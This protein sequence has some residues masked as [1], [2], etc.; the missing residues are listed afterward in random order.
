[1]RDGHLAPYQELAWLTEPLDTERAWLA[2]HDTPLPRADHRAARRRRERRISFPALGDHARCA[3]AAARRRRRRGAAGRTSSTRAPALA[4]AG[5]RFLALGRPDAAGRRPARRGATAGRPTST[6]GS[7]CSR[8]TRCAA[9]TPRTR[10]R[11]PTRYAAIGA[12]L[13]ELGFQL[14]RQRDPPRHVGGRPAAHRL[15]GQGARAGRGAGG[16]DGGARRRAAR[17]RPVRRRAGRGA[18]RRR[19]RPAC[20]T[21][22][23]ARPATRCWRSRDDS[24][25]APL[26]PLLVSGR[27]LRC[28][29]G[30][31]DVAARGARQRQAAEHFALP[32]WEAEP[33]RPARLAAVSGRGVGAARVGRARHAR[34]S[35]AASTERWSAPAR[36]SA[37]AG[38]ARRS[39]ASSTSRSPRPAS[40]CSRCAA[41]RCGSTPP[42]REK[43]ASNWD[44]VCV[45]PEPRA[46]ERRLRALRAQAPAPVRARRGRRD[47]GRAVARAPGAGPVRAA[48]GEPASTSSTARCAP[49]PAPSRRRASAGRSA[50]PTAAPTSARWS[51]ADAGATVPLSADEVRGSDPPGVS[52]RIPVGRG[53]GCRGARDRRVPGDRDGAA[54]RAAGG[55][56]AGAGLGG[57]PA[58]AGAEAAPD[59]APARPLGPRGGRRLPRARRDVGRGRR[60]ADDRAARVRLPALRP[61]PRPHRRRARASPTRSTS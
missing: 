46:R 20:S 28:L 4:R 3:S 38:T 1:M 16:R 5:V 36:C 2:E 57:V 21:R 11:R 51:S 42:T 6:T 15:A 37:R 31:A 35:R 30:D 59:R 19:A 60:V 7:C 27:G 18:A 33:G 25:T 50:S 8:T 23:R 41:A 26:R 44:V 43:L 12:A 17:A 29:P 47:R 53:G 55:R 52:Q 45:A 39:T 10:A 48:A 58:R 54:A 49:A 13:R 14:T 32:E 56:A 9:C 34:C 24:R 61:Q 22:P 40:R